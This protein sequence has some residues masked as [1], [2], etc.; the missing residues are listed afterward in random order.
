MEL[1]QW[2]L[3]NELINHSL[4]FPGHESACTQYGNAETSADPNIVI[5]G[6]SMLGTA[7]LWHTSYTSTSSSS[8]GQHDDLFVL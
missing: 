2:R 8:T 1:E 4:I 7:G 3:I 6:H 5:T